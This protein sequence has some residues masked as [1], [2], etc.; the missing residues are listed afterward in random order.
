MSSHQ[1]ELT[2]RIAYN[3]FDRDYT[4]YAT[5]DGVEQ[6]IGVGESS[7]EAEGICR[8][9]RFNHYS[10]NHTPEKAAQVA[11]ET[12]DPSPSALDLPPI[13]VLA[14]VAAELATAAQD[15]D[16]TANMN[17]LNKAMLQLHAGTVP[18]PT[19]GGF[20][21]ESRTRGGVVHRVSTVHG[22]SCE[23]GSKGR[24]CWHQS[25][26]ELIVAAQQRAALA[27]APFCFFHPSADH[28]TR[29]CPRVDEPGFGEPSYSV[30][31]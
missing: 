2:T 8:D 30:F 26:I 9:Y 20:L 23:A 17:A 7:T 12:F 29:N 24:I 21:V 10:D 18:V 22:C 6:I 28:D 27:T 11:A 31:N 3:K 13:N 15:A 1:R 19:T 25:L 4:C 5:I 16:D 14:D